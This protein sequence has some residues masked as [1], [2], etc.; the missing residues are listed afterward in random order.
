[1]LH[2]FH[3]N[4]TPDNDYIWSDQWNLEDISIFSRDQQ[5]EPQNLDIGERAIQGFCRPRIV[6]IAGNPK[7]KEFDL[8]NG[9]LYVEFD[10]DPALSAPS[11]IYVLHIQLPKGFTLDTINIRVSSDKKNQLLLLYSLS[12]DARSVKITRKG[13]LYMDLEEDESESD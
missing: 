8:K 1:M 7:A 4:C 3:W 6:S 2:V 12:K 13:E 11:V 5:T 10:G 9:I